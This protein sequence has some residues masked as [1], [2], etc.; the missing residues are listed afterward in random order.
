LG[1]T[2]RLFFGVGISL[3]YIYGAVLPYHLV[4]LASIPF[5]I[6]FLYAFW[7]VPETPLHLLKCQKFE[8]KFEKAF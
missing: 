6:V 7:R 3:A 4:P 5:S 8:V 2:L 1:S